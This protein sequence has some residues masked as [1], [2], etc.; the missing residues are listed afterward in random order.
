MAEETLVESLISD[1]IT[2]VQELDKQ[3]PGPSN[4]IWYYFSDAEVWRLLIAGPTFDQ[5]LPKEEVRAYEI[6]AKAIT[7]AHLNSLTIADVK[8]IRTNDPVLVATKFVLRTPAN[9]IVRA[10]F[11]DNVF[12]GIFVKEMLILRAAQT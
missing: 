7:G 10:H 4:V 9:G 12:N 8:L 2:L 11:R 5:L 6:C 3:A 1:S